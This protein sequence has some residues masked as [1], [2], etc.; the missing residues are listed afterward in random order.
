M[1]NDLVDKQPERRSGM[2]RRQIKFT[3][4]IPERRSGNDRRSPE[5]QKKKSK[6]SSR[7]VT[8]K[9]DDSEPAKNS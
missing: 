1:G 9:Q 3:L 8:G 7:I 6:T 5:G 4:H 2:E